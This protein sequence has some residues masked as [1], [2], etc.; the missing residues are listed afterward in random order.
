MSDLSRQNHKHVNQIKVLLD[1]EYEDLLRC[2]AR[3]HRTPKAVL[4]REVLK[5]WLRDVVADSK[6]DTH[7]A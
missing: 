5:S 1:D 3:I 7:V 4:A 6:A 2:A